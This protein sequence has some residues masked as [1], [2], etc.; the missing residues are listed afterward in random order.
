M[1]IF[2][3][4]SDYFQGMISHKLTGDI[5]H[6]IFPSKCG[7]CGYESPSSQPV[8][9]FCKEELHYTS[10]ELSNEPNE[11]DKLFWGRVHVKGTYSLLYFSKNTSTQKLL[12]ALKYQNKPETGLVLGREIGERLKRLTIF[13]DVDA[14]IPVPL[15]PKKRFVRGYNQSEQLA[16]GISQVASIEVDKHVIRK[17][18]D[19]VSQTR[20]GRF[21]RWENVDGNFI[22]RDA[23]KT[24]RHIAIV[25]DVITTGATLESLINVIH[26]KHP[27]LRVSIISLALTK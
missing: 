7:V 3:V 6:L 11:L 24:Y 17:Q 27:K 21:E 26:T 23:I 25:D 9:Q 14:L 12:H 8:C 19:T 10:F 20:R 22:V 4:V 16:L 13:N 15:H 18:K 1:F 2:R 5:L